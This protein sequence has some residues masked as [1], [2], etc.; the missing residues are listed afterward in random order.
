MSP[1]GYPFFTCTSACIYLIEKS[2]AFEDNQSCIATAKS[3][4]ISPRTKHI[5]THVHFFRSHIHDENDN[6]PEGDVR[7]ECVD[8]KVHQPADMLTK[9]LGVEQFVKLRKIAF[10][11]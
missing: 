2:T 10:G 1:R 9:S 3:K 5:A 7:I 11:W 8:T 4:K 6:H